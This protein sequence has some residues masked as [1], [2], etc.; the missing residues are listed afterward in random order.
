MVNLFKQ[1]FVFLV[2]ENAFELWE[3]GGCGLSEPVYQ[4]LIKAL[5]GES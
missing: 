1:L 5:L 2:N 4:V 3:K